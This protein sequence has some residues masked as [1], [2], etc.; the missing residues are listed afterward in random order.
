V[1]SSWELDDEE[2]FTL[3]SDRSAGLD[4]WVYSWVEKH[5]IEAGDYFYDFEKGSDYLKKTRHTT[6]DVFDVEL[7]GGVIAQGI[8]YQYTLSNGV[9]RIWRVV[10]CAFDGRIYEFQLNAPVDTFQLKK[11]TIEQVFSSI[12]LLKYQTTGRGGR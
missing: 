7:A 9:S 6:S 8:D 12:H 10:Y 5:P 2:S 4:F 3:F 1:P 11:N